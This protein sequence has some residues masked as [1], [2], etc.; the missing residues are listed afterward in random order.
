MVM[1]PGGYTPAQMV[2]IGVA[3]SVIGSGMIRY[4]FVFEDLK[5]T[6]DFNRVYEASF[7]N[8]AFKDLN[9]KSRHIGQI[10]NTLKYV[11]HDYNDPSTASFELPGMKQLEKHPVTGDM[12]YLRSI[13][14]NLNDDYKWSR[15][16]IA[17]W[18]E[19]LD[20]VPVFEGGTSA[21]TLPKIANVVAIQ[22]ILPS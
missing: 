7:V 22:R 11:S 8:D 13:I 1:H 20:T 5:L 18:I 3:V 14:M 19:T 10:H 2:D 4:C 17:D 16:K 9:L 12:L 21:R 6:F 15:E